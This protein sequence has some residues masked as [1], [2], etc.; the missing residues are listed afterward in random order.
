MQSR[1]KPEAASRRLGASEGDVVT[2]LQQ[3]CRSSYAKFI[4]ACMCLPACCF[5]YTTSVR[6]FIRTFLI[7][8]TRRWGGK[9]AGA[10]NWPLTSI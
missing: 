8:F 4:S 6:Q 1:V 2:H 9:A 5:L 3:N 10:W 7:L